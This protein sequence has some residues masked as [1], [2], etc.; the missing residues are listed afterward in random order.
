MEIK[1]VWNRLFWTIVVVVV[2]LLVVML[3]VAPSYSKWSEYYKNIWPGFIGTSFGVLFSAGFA[4]AFMMVQERLRMKSEEK[5]RRD[6]LH[7]EA[8]SELKTWEGEV[9]GFL[10]SYYLE[11]PTKDFRVLFNDLNKARSELVGIS[12]HA[13]NV[14]TKVKNIQGVDLVSV[15]N[16]LLENIEELNKYFGGGR[17]EDEKMK[18]MFDKVRTNFKEIQSTISGI[19]SR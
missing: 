14:K 16:E 18:K 19:V 2:I 13:G 5:E 6:N 15:F 11:E 9:S 12:S 7:N 3:L 1:K 4:G 17:Y 8:L 10:S